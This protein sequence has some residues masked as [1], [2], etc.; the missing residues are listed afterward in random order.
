MIACV[1]FPYFAATLTQ[2]DNPGLAGPP[3][4]FGDIYIDAVSQEAAWR[5]IRPDMTVREA[6]VLCPGLRVTPA[7]HARTHHAF[8]A[9]LESLADFTHLVEPVSA[10][11]LRADA[12][13]RKPGA[14]LRPCQVDTQSAAASILDLGSLRVDEA[15]ELG[16]H[17]LRTLFEQHRLMAAIGMASGKF[18]ARLVASSLHSGE[19][20]L[21]ERGGEAQFLS[22]YPIT[23]LPIDGEMIRQLH[24]LG[25]TTLGQIAALPAGAL[26]D[27]FGQQGHTIHRLARG[28]DTSP[29]QPYTPRRSERL[30]RQLDGPAGDRRVLENVTK[31]MT[32]T[33]VVRLQMDGLMVREI[34]L[35]L[36]LED[37]QTLEEGLVLRQPAGTA[38][39]LTRVAHDLLAAMWV[40]C[41]VVEVTITLDD[42]VP[43]VARQLSLFDRAPVPQ[44]RLRAVLKDLVARYGEDC[45]YWVTLLDPEARLPERRFQLKKV[46]GL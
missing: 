36:G 20:M 8:E 17:I 37:G 42:L 1:R 5:G 19:I 24:L 41:R 34:T 3:L 15:L 11:E 40:P 43:A 39:H 44:E 2:R 31:A 14:Y 22:A 23:T 38:G 10:L 12:R 18:I 6:Q 9:I 35:A 26:L 45:F 7:A 13:R 16:H 27:R 4:V 25:L 21:I 46:S 29:V 28:H 30:V 32:E 33:L